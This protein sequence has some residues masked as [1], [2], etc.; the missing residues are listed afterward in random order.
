MI[1]R[2][3]YK[4]RALLTVC[5]SGLLSL[6][7]TTIAFAQ[8]TSPAGVGSVSPL[9]NPMFLPILG[10]IAIVVLVVSL[11][12]VF[13][14]NPKDFPRTE[15]LGTVWPITKKRLW[16]LIGV[17]VFLQVFVQI[18][19]FLT[20]VVQS[21][22][23]LSNEE[24]ISSGLNSIVSFVLG[25]IAQSG[26]V[27]LALHLVDGTQ[28]RFSDLFSQLSVFWRYVG[29]TILYGLLVGIGLILLV[30]P[31]MYWML[32]YSLWPYLLVD[33]RVSIIDA[34]KMS[35]RATYGHK[36]SLFLLYIFIA[37]LN[38]VGLFVFVVGYLVTA[39]LSALIL[40]YVY[41]K[42][43]REGHPPAPA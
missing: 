3:T 9:E 1:Q 10:G 22:M 8:G 13:L 43:T 34:F 30:A 23:N 19:T 12:I 32:K 28:A 42:L 15:V 39:P 4:G 20:A 6:M 29:A 26:F 18:P 40:A 33:K 41:R 24:P 35:A 17:F 2:N 38:I 31:G 7:A 14:I 37:G 36:W 5:A 21:A 25:V 16:F 11:L 27:A